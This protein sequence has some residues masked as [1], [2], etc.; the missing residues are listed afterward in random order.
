[1]SAYAN[2][3]KKCNTCSGFDSPG[4]RS[5]SVPARCPEGIKLYTAP[6]KP[7]KPSMPTPAPTISKKPEVFPPQDATSG[8]MTIK[9]NDDS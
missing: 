1:M 3:A 5:Y 7:R 6:P 4:T 9:V 8:H 2:H